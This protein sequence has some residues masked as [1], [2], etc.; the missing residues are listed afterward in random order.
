MKNS[1][2]QRYVLPGLVFQSVVIAGGYGTGREIVEFFL[3]LGPKGG[4]LAMAVSTIIWSAVCAVSFEFGRAFASY[5]YRTFFQHLLGRAG[6]LF[7]ICYFVFLAIVLAVIA[8]AAGSILEETFGQPYVVGVVGMMAAIGFLVFKGTATIEKFLA[9]WSFVL[10]AVYV[11]LFVWSFL[12]FGDQVVDKMRSVPVLPGWFVGGVKYAAYNL[13]TIPAIL[14]CIR[15]IERRREAVWAGVL[16]GPIAM[17]PALLFFVAMA[18]HY[19]EIVDRAV[20]ANF[21]LETLGSRTFQIAFQVVLFGTLVETGT[22][23]IHAVNERVS[24][25]YERQDRAMPPALRVALGTGLLLAGT[26]IAQFG[27][28]SLI[29]RGYGT[30]TWLFLLIFVIPVLTWGIV[31]LSRRSAAETF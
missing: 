6:V 21:I 2:F 1:L 13:A 16:A 18:G 8:A 4:L 15:H 14:F 30:L 3:T 9:S 24:T 5:D 22:G 26:F 20:P 17:L 28:I 23:M 10:Y 31:K 11:V 27:L 25:A 12:S 29:A 7:E 19:P